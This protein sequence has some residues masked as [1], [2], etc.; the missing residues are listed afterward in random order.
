MTPAS[1]VRIARQ[2]DSPSAGTGDADTKFL[3]A[4]GE[5]VRHERSQ[6]NLTRRTLAENSRVSERYV[7]QLESGKGNISVLLLRKIANALNLPLAELLQ[8]GND[9]SRE[10]GLIRQLLEK[11]PEAR[12]A[13]LRKRLMR[14]FNLNDAKPKNRIALVG[15][16]GAGK[17]TLG[18]MLAKALGLPF[19]ELDREIERAAGMDQAEIFLLYG[20]SGYRR[21]ESQCLE[22]TLA[23]N[24]RAVISVGGGIV[25]QADTYNSLLENCFTVW[26]KATPEE[27]MSRVIAQGDMRP[28]RG[29]KEAMQDLKNLLAGREQLYAKADFTLDTSGDTPKRSLQKINLALSH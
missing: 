6:R 11:M 10:L 21:L 3:R 1:S 15:L 27:H 5:R 16:R 9:P 17:S 23:Q 19:I 13:A 29:H 14:D 24:E 18:G 26:I 7:A 28:M 4:L 22:K 12:L 2:P 25:S 8:P 20:D